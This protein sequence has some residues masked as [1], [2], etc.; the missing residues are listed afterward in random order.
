MPSYN[1]PQVVHGAECPHC[2][3]WVHD[4]ELD[5]APSGYCYP[6]DDAFNEEAEADAAAALAEMGS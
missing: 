2:L 4:N 5:L 6:C 1:D 3:T